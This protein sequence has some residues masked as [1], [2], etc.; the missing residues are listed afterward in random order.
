MARREIR[1]VETPSDCSLGS[2]STKDVALS[3]IVRENNARDIT[4]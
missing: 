4:E 1:V 2:I 3:E